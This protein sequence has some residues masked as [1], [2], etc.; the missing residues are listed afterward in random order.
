MTDCPAALRINHCQSI[1]AARDSSFPDVFL[2]SSTLAAART[3]TH[4][5]LMAFPE[6]VS[7]MQLLQGS[8][9]ATP[10]LT[11]LLRIRMN[12][13]TNDTTSIIALPMTG[14]AHG[15]RNG[16]HFFSGDLFNN[17]L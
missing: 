2:P 10:A 12:I 6:K 13:F 17:R 14:S 8:R 3:L 16:R 11:I 4:I 5:M 15:L 7:A 1:V 9:E